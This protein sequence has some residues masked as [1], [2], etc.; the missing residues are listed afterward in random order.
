MIAQIKAFKYKELRFLRP[1]AF[2]NC[3]QKKGKRKIYLA[4]G[5]KNAAF[6]FQEIQ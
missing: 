1:F 6:K 3:G 4:P 2:G 5:V